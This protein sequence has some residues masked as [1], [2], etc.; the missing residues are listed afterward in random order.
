[1]KPISTSTF[2]FSSLID[3]GYIYVDKTARIHTLASVGSIF[4][5]I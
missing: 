5:P 4:L 2:T 1:M 3:G